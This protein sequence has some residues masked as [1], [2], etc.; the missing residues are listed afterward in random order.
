MSARRAKARRAEAEKLRRYVLHLAKVVMPTV[1]VG[2][3]AA[4]YLPDG[5]THIL[6][7]TATGPVLTPATDAEVALYLLPGAGAA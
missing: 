4:V 3:G 7:M 5:S 2:D 1:E 6:Q